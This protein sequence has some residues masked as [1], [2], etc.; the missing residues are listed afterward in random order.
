MP[1]EKLKAVEFR[2]ATAAQNGRELIAT[3]FLGDRGVAKARF[4]DGF[5]ARRPR[6][7]GFRAR[8]D[9]RIPETG[10]AS[11]P[12]TKGSGGGKQPMGKGASRWPER[13]FSAAL[14]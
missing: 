1:A 5:P 2:S 12:P 4:G 14:L 10:A 8:L 3:A 13:S 11:Y 7:R 9:T 6:I